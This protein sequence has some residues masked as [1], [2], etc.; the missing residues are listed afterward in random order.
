MMERCMNSLNIPIILL[1][2]D[3]YIEFSPQGMFLALTLQIKKALPERNTLQLYK[4]L[5]QT[6]Q[7]F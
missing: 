6:K 3:G 2:T 4:S 1:V 7:Q 5:L